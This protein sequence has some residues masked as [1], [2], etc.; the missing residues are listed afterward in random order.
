AQTATATLSGTVTDQNGAV[1]PNANV[2]IVSNATGLKR[3]AVTNDGGDFTAPLLQPGAYTV[4]AQHD[5]F[6]IVQIDNVILNVG[7]RKTI[8]IALQTGDVTETVVVTGEAPLINESPAVATVVDRQFVG[9]MP[10][11]GRSLQSLISLTPGVVFATTGNN[12]HTGGQF[13]VNGQRTN[14]NYFTVDGVS[15]NYGITTSTTGFVGQSGTGSLPGLTALG[16]TNSLVSV[17]A[18]QEFRIQT[19]SYAPEFG[20]TPGGQ[21]SLL[22]R[23]GTN[24]YHG[25]L[26]DYLRND[27][28]DA[29]DWFANRSGF[30]RA[31]NR[32]ND[33]GGVLGGP[34]PLPGFGEGGPTFHRGKDRTFFFFSYEG[35]RLRQPL[36]TI[37]RVPSMQARQDAATVVKPFF[38]AFPIPNLPVVAPGLAQFAASYSNP[39]DVDATNIR[40][41]HSFSPKLLLFGTYKHSPSQTAA[42]TGALNTIQFNSFKNDALTFA[43]TWLVSSALSNDLRFNWSRARATQFRTSDNFGGAILP[44]DSLLFTSPRNRNNSN[45]IWDV[46]NP[47][48]IRSGM[49]SIGVGQNNFEQQLNLID[50]LSWIK[51]NHQLKFG[52]DYR[53][54]T[55]HLNRNGSNFTL[56]DFSVS[57]QPTLS[58]VQKSTGELVDNIVVF[59]NFSAFAQDTWKTNNRLTLTY[60]LRWDLNPPPYSANGQHPSILL[61]VGGTAPATFAPPGTPLYKTQYSAFAPRFGASLQ[62]SQKPGRETVLR[63]G[64]GLFYDLGTGQ[65]ANEFSSIYP[66]FAFSLLSNVSYPL[67]PAQAA[68]PVLGTDRPQQFYLADQNLKLPYTAQW[69]LALEQ[70]FGNNQ[71]VTISYVG[72]AGR[73]LLRFVRSFT[74]VAGFGSAPIFYSLN[75]NDGTSDYRALQ[76]QFQ[77]RLSKGIQ[78]LLSYTCGRSYDDS[79]S[80]TGSVGTDSPFL[81]SKINYAP[82]DFDVRHILSGTLTVDIP[83][84]RG[85]QTINAITRGWGLDGLVRFR[86]ALPTTLEATNRIGGLFLSNRPNVVPGVAQILFGAQFPGGKAVNTA[87]FTNPPDETIGNF[88]RNSLRFFN[89]SQVDMAMRREFGLQEKLKLQLRFEFFNIFNHP[90]FSDPTGFTTGTNVSTQMLSRGLGGL[91]PLYQIG[92]PRSGQVGLKI[93]F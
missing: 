21:I 51:A 74:P 84:I 78:G 80:D 61:G 48:R 25:T 37:A 66:Y 83:A 58:L 36:T 33:F 29:N 75:N 4:R 9:N 76:L 70:S 92:G 65:L 28:L 39:S 16:G 45:A 69:N 79:S 27:V 23:S 7:D 34:L 82:S 46:M 64:G 24:A 91:N 1:V 47:A 42:R 2:T 77:R 71:S 44:D 32:Q 56:I 15:A 13:S 11:N 88:R 10:L 5:G 8:Q 43:L 89:A 49:I 3:D 20:R 57:P 62:I 52:V 38:N 18:L 55:P 85:P 63:G 30:P 53:R 22:T 60:G 90:N 19:S 35:L 50:T 72:A 67:T 41:D 68:P 87:A 14:A 81:S 6:K 26:F 31:K 54:I 40:I 59:N 93:I 17:D 86:T 73:R 12:S